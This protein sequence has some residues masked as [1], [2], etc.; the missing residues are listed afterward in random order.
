MLTRMRDDD[1]SAAWS[2]VT[3]T[4]PGGSRYRILEDGAALGFDG[5]LLR[6]ATDDAFADWYSA[7]IADTP[8]AAVYWENP[9]LSRRLRRRPAEF[10]LMEAPELA[11]MRP[12]AETFAGHF[13]T[14]DDRAVVTFSNLG[15]DALLV[16]PVP[17][18]GHD[19]Y[20]HLA[21][22]LRLGPRE[23]IRELWRRT[24]RAV[25]GRLGDAPLWLST[26]GTGVAWL[27][28]RLDQRPKYYQ[29][30]PWKQTP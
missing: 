12:D 10:V 11:G 13:E 7:L 4:L 3:E 20:P 21:A 2:A 17:L 27:H 28:V 1:R 18:D 14:P 22:F 16:V 24:A 23:Q 8:Y 5:L 29:Y 15:G 6:L 19:A 9:P 30:R 26:S 25:A